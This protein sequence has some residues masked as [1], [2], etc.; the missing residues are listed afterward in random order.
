MSK[1]QKLKALKEEVEQLTPEERR[2]W[3]QALTREKIQGKKVMY[4]GREVKEC[5]LKIA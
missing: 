5:T 1:E 4:K 2:V 3:F